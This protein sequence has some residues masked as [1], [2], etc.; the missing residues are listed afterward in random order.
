MTQF[1]I[2][3]L[4]K[5]MLTE[6]VMQKIAKSGYID[7][8]FLKKQK[9]VITQEK[10]PIIPIPDSSDKEQTHAHQE[11]NTNYSSEIFYPEE[12]DSLFWSFY[13]LCYG[14]ENYQN[15]HSR[16]IVVE[17]KL[18]IEFIEMFRDNKAVLPRLKEKR[19]GP[20]SHIENS[21]LNEKSIDLKTFEA[22]CV[23]KDI[24]CVYLFD[25]CYHPINIED[26]ENNELTHIPLIVKKSYPE[27]YGYLDK[28]SLTEIINTKYKVDNISK[29]LKAM[30]SYKLEELVVLCNKL[31]IQVDGNKRK[32]N[33]YEELVK[34]I[35]V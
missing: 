5:Y 24:S 12:K 32:K 34:T 35:C 30:T 1:D 21:L 15:L 9:N 3:D 23:I 26:D 13:I 31:N 7:T 11:I 20:I 27:K 8:S 16:N 19:L 6:N 17:K 28:C 10:V 18:K 33:L 14:D 2:Q 4:E 29:P 25:K 22:L